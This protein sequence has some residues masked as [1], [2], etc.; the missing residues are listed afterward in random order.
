[1]DYGVNSFKKVDIFYPHVFAPI[2]VENGK[3]RICNLVYSGKIP[4]LIKENDYIK[5]IYY[6][7]EKLE[8]P[9]DK[10]TIIGKALYYINNQLIME[11]PILTS[12]S[13]AEIDFGYCLDKARSLW[14]NKVY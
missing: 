4:L 13:V 9:V 3:E 2:L 11:I 8:A 1:M 14:L 7:A 5:I 12:D 6:M 10:N